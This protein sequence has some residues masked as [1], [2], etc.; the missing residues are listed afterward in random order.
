M[1]TEEQVKELAYS[2]WEQEGCPAGKH[3]EHYYHAKQRL[4]ERESRLVPASN[5][6]STAPTSARAM[7]SPKSR[8]SKS[9]SKKR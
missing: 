9:P 2:I 6:V 7:S 5:P 1:V 4:E 3:L 8:G